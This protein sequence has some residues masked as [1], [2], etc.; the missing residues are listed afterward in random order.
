MARPGGWPQLLL[1]GSIGASWPSPLRS[2][3]VPAKCL[4]AAFFAI[5]L[6]QNSL[7][8]HSSGI[9]QRRHS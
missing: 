4:P 8:G 3:T 5:G 6:P 9:L 2:A 1:A 7:H